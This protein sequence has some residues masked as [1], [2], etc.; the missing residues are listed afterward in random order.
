M[1]TPP[2][3]YAKS[4][5]AS[6]A[7]QVVGDGPIDLVLVLGFATHLELQW[8][9]PAFAR[10]FERIS[11]FSRLIDLRQA[12][13]RALRP[14]HRGADA[15]AADRRRPGGHGRRRVRA[16][17]PVRDLRGRADERPVRGHSPR[18]RDRSGALRRHGAHHRGARLPLG[19]ARGGASRVRRRVHR[20]LLGARRNG[21]GGAVRSEPRGRSPRRRSSPRA[22]SAPPRV[23]RWSS[24]SSRCSWT[25]TCE[26]SCPRSDVPTLVLHRRGDRVVNRRAGEELASQIPG[27]RYVELPGI[28]HLPWAGDSEGRA[29]GDRGVPDRR[30]L[31]TRARPRPR[32]GDVHGHRRLHASERRRSGTRAGASCSQRIRQACDAS[33]GDSAAAR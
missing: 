16:G 32:H 1:S 21:D 23:R 7:Y 10:F 6:I 24:R 17:G 18:A 3:Q 25:S 8:E 31:G 2:T 9:S 26:P 19:L 30:P 28:D 27:A 5:D 13:H 11:S 22:W 20:P 4:G 33:W 15:R 12:R 29:R 14:R